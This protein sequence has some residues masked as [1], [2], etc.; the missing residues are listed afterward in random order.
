MDEDYDDVN[1]LLDVWYILAPQRFAS[2]KNQPIASLS[3]DNRYI[4]PHH[5]S[6]PQIN[7][8]IDVLPA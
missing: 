2:Q 6:S 7:E 8:V 1:S 3:V 4:L 5:Q